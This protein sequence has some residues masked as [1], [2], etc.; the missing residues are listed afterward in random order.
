LVVPAYNE[1]AA[2]LDA[3]ESHLARHDGDAEII[4]V[5]DGS[6]DDTAAIVEAR[7]PAPRRDAFR[8][9]ARAAPFGSLAR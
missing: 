9:F 7:A 2:T 8:F 1:A 4:V 5:D 6:V 3:L